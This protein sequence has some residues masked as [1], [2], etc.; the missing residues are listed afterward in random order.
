MR[1]AVAAVHPDR[2][3]DAQWWAALAAGPVLCGLLLTSSDS[4]FDPAWIVQRPEVFLLLALVY[5]VLEEIVFRGLIQ[6]SLSQRLAAWRRGPVSKANL[7]TSLLFA[8]LH[9]FSHPPLWAAA[10][11]IPSLVFGHFRERHGGLTS[12]I[13]LHAFYNGVYFAL[14][15]IP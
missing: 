6:G 3:A 5:P 7:L 9:G 4:Y 15:G 8:V 13:L 12:P 2:W 14:F 11:F 1:R 10:V